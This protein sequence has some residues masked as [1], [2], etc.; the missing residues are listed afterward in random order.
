MRLADAV[1][2]D[3]E[4]GVQAARAGE[5]ATELALRDGDRDGLA[6]P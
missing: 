3:V 1:D 4:D 6:V 2:L 5:R